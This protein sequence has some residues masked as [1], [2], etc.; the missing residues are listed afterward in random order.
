[1]IGTPN[2][3]DSVVRLQSIHF[4]EKV[5]SNPGAYEGVD[6][7][8]DE[9]TRCHPSSH[10]EDLTDSVFW[11]YRVVEGLHVERLNFWRDSFRDVM[12]ERSGGDGLSILGY[13]Q[14]GTMSRFNL[15]TPGGP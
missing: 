1:M 13:Y 12:H 6:V 15:L 5:T 14:Y 8:E 4:V 9:E 11:P 7:F 10:K 2:H 3:Q